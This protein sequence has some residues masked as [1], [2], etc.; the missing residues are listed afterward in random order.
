MINKVL[1][2]VCLSVAVVIVVAFL[3]ID[4]GERYYSSACNE[5]RNT[6][7]DERKINYFWKYAL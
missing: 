5:I 7:L 1:T 3:L 4:K 2:C 6:A